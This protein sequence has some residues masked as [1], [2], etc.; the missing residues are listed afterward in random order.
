MKN[1]LNGFLKRST[2]IFKNTFKISSIQSVMTLSFTF[3]TILTILF[4]GITLY[5]KF[6]ETAEKNA[7]HNIDQIIDQVSLNLE[8]YLEGM[9]EV[10]DFIDE[11]LKSYYGIDKSD[12]D[13]TFK[14]TY[15]LRKDIVSMVLLSDKAELVAGIPATNFKK[16]VKFNEQEWYKKALEEPEKLHI[17]PPH[18][19]SLYHGKHSWVVSLSRA[20]AFQRDGR[21]VQGVTLVDMNF[22][23]IDKLCQRVSLGKKGYIFIV[24]NKGNLIYHPQQ[25]IVYAGLKNENIEEI[26]E[27]GDGRF[28]QS[29]DGI[30]RLVT[31]KTEKYAGWKIV[32]VS[33]IDEIVATKKEI[34][35]FVLYI[36]IFG[37]IFVIAVSVFI[38][39][40]ISQPIK[41]LEKSMKKVEAGDM[42]IFIDVKGEDEVKQLSRTFIMM[43]ARIKKLMKENME[44]QEAKRKSQLMALQAQINPHFLYN[45]LDSIV[46][47]AENGKV[48]GVITM[49]AALAKLFR[50]SINRGEE[51]TTVQNELEHAKSYLTIQEIRYQDKFDFEIKAEEEILHCKT[52]KIILQPLIENAI[53]H[54]IEKMVDK[55]KITITASRKNNKILLQVTDDGIGM[56]EETVKSILNVVSK[57]RTSSGVGV[58][59]V[60]ERIRLYFGDEYGLEIFSE[61]DE[62]T[63]VNVWLPNLGFEDGGVS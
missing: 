32:G 57:S 34:N 60:H 31:V 6:S 53:Y 29:L 36:I 54:G 8:Y 43:I 62:G 59:N 20:T 3:F 41:R 48:D 11:S 61:L 14:T 23:T 13:K 30:Q 51:I 17:F 45:T 50:I 22:S 58:K 4:V 52:L 27:V 21:T 1:K 46:W 19:Q 37:V 44:E 25:Q 5:N 47:M 28:E 63:T 40:R 10:S 24:D 15:M 18:V 38:S 12:L 39:S 56:S 33:Y 55:G 7:A 9:I 35:S 16:N 2:S 49:V 42:D 26:L